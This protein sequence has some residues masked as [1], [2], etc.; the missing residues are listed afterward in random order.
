MSDEYEDI[1]REVIRDISFLSDLSDI[2]QKRCG[3]EES[4]YKLA[5]L[6]FDKNTFQTYDPAIFRVIIDHSYTDK[7]DE[8][9]NI[10]RALGLPKS[11]T[12]ILSKDVFLYNA[13]SD[14]TWEITNDMFSKKIQH[15]TACRPQIIEG[16]KG[17]TPQGNIYFRFNEE[18]EA[19]DMRNALSEIKKPRLLKYGRGKI[20]PYS[21]NYTTQKCHLSLWD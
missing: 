8:I 5:M 14:K 10:F 20:A 9:S 21:I 4:S 16:D 7:I 2:I 12:R 17:I 1:Q 18:A 11:N 6:F 13:L 3:I 19:Q 15:G